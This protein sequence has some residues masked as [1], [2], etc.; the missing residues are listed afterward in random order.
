MIF[1]EVLKI[2]RLCL[3]FAH[4][5]FL[6]QTKVNKKKQDKKIKQ[7]NKNK[8]KINPDIS[9][10]RA[11][12]LFLLNKNFFFA[13]IMTGRCHHQ[14]PITQKHLCM[15]ESWGLPEAETY[16]IKIYR[17]MGQWTNHNTVLHFCH[18]FNFLIY[19]CT[20]SKRA[21]AYNG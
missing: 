10:P 21:F 6:N 4:L 14:K 9:T 1:S 17:S 3:S 13:F 15:S 2:I 16:P 8:Q 11:V 19:F 18:L 12:W 5:T 7:T 20:Q